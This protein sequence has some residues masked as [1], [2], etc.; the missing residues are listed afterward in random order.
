MLEKLP[1]DRESR[2]RKFAIKYQDDETKEPRK[3]KFFIIAGMYADKRIGEVFIRGDKIGGFISGALD[4]LAM[5]ISIGLQHGVPLQAITGKLRYNQFGPSGFTGDTTFRSCTS[6]FDLVAQWL[7]YEF[8]DGRL[9]ANAG[10]IR[11]SAPV[12]PG[13]EVP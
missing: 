11:Q 10:E 13:K 9:R 12:D 4:A 1:D 3:L 5:T 2:T 8:P 6:M 7:D